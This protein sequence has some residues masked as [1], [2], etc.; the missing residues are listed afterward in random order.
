[1]RREEKIV[2]MAVRGEKD[3][4]GLTKEEGALLGDISKRVHKCRDDISDIWNGKKTDD[5]AKKVKI[6]KDIEPYTG[7]DN[8]TYGPYSDG[9][10]PFLPQAEADWLIKSKMAQRG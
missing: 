6:L 9:D 4:P 7:L 3:M 8:N 2:F 10:E 5:T 1:M